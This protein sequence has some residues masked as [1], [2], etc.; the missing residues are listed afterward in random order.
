LRCRGTLSGHREPLYIFAQ[1]LHK[2][3]QCLELVTLCL[4]LRLEPSF[5]VGAATRLE[6]LELGHHRITLACEHEN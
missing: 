2:P 5:S 6:F 3:D 4:D 1:A